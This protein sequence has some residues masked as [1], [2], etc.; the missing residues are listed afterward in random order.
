MLLL[1]FADECW[2]HTSS[3]DLIRFE[4]TDGYDTF[5]KTEM[6]PSTS[7]S[8]FVVTY[9]EVAGAYSIGGTRV[10]GVSNV[11]DCKTWCTAREEC[12]A[13]DF[14]SLNRCFWHTNWEDQ[15][16]EGANDVTQYRKEPRVSPTGL[17]GTGRSG[18]GMLISNAA[19]NHLDFTAKNTQTQRWASHGSEKPTTNPYIK[20]NK[21]HLCQMI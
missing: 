9:V 4:N 20:L 8:A 2:I 18:T 7:V 1:L 12:I 3:D 15:L 17:T 11:E 21:D 19:L 6:C 13:F 10:E 5:I 14:N 16:Q